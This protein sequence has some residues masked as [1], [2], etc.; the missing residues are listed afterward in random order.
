[1]VEYTL[2]TT[3]IRCDTCTRTATA[4]AATAKEEFKA[5]G[6]YINP[7]GRKYKH[8]CSMCAYDKLNRLTFNKNYNRQ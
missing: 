4:P 7:K 5:K 1:M 8:V 2:T 3:R 6:W